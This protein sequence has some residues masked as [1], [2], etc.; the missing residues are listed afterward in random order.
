MPVYES[1]LVN[2]NAF[3]AISQEWNMTGG[4]I[5][6]MI[7]FSIIIGIWAN[8]RG[9]TGFGWG[10]IALLI[11]PLIAGI[12]LVILTNLKEE[13]DLEDAAKEEQDKQ[14][15]AAEQEA[16]KISSASFIESINNLN[17]LYKNGIVD[18]AEFKRKKFETI[19][20][21]KKRLLVDNKTEFVAKLIP[22]MNSK[23]L[24]NTDIFAIK[25]AI[26]F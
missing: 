21:L 2:I 14:E 3:I 24:D 9:R 17:E 12:I 22:L 26:A 19:D 11:S 6:F 25:E 16:K 23:V 4:V 10:I 15:K 18:D 20:N 1:R 13:Q 5:F 8:K 7:M